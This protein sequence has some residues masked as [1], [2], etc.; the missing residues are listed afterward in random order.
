M[1]KILCMLISIIVFGSTFLFNVQAQQPT[2]QIVSKA[3]NEIIIHITDKNE[4][5]KYQESLNEEYDPNLIEVYKIEKEENIVVNDNKNDSRALGNDFYIKNKVTTNST[6]FTKLLRQYNR[7]AGTVKIKD[8]ISIS[9]EFSAEAGVDAEVIT[10]QLGYSVTATNTF[11]IEWTNK[12]SYPITIKI[13]PIYSITKGEL[14]EDDIF[15]DDN[16]GKF[17]SKRAVGDEIRVYKNS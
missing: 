15:F 8:S 2:E 11:S 12:Y 9:N 4:I 14:W 7:P 16:I 10:A 5:Q 1:K 3:E 13:Y 6:D 17:T